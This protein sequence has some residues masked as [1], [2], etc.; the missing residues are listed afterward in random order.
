MLVPSISSE[1]CEEWLLPRNTPVLHQLA[2][3]SP[4]LKRNRLR[5][6]NNVVVIM[7]CFGLVLRLIMKT[8]DTQQST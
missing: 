8:E 1:Q 2:Y 7:Q 5:A 4:G 3:T 6:F